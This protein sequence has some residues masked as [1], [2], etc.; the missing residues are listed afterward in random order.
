MGVSV[1]VGTYGHTDWKH[2]ARERAIPSVPEGIPVHHVHA[3]SLAEARNGGLAQVET[4]WVVH[5]D[6]DDEL[7]VGYFDHLSRGVADLRA[8]AVRYVRGPRERAAYVPRVAG[9]DHDCSAACL[10]DGNWLV[11]GTMAR[12]E[13]LRSVGGWEDW[14]LYEDWAIWLRCYLDGATIEALPAA[15]Y[16]AHVSPASRNRSPA[17]SFKNRVHEDIVAAC[18]PTASAA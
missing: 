2:L 11:V 14:P 5:L 3:A 18:L 17:I 4:E 7:E 6:A 15:V 9:H 12:T 8:P 1:V 10:V 13:L 16:R